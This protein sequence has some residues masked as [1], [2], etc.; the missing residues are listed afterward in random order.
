MPIDLEIKRSENIFLLTPKGSISADDF[1]KCSAE[2]NNYINEH[3]A[4]P[5]LVFVVANLPHW[6]DFEAMSAH[7]HLVKDHHTIIPKVALVSDSKLLAV[8]RVFADLFIGARIRRFPEY[9]LDDAINWAAMETDNPGSF[10]VM[11][12]LPADTIGID[13]RGLIGAS[14]YRDTLEPL[15]DGK[16]KEHDKLKLL[17]VAGPYFDGYSAGAMWDDARFGLNHLT[18][19]SKMALVTDHDWL[20]H[21]AKMF[22]MLMPTEVMVFEM[23]ELEDAKAWIKT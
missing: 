9:A 20:R 19:F 8:I 21:S 7:F 11:D 3:D 10:I 5:S 6:K 16:L 4:I 12:G 14:E 23:A 2:L 17:A 1:E 15:V 13:A 18:T 22:G